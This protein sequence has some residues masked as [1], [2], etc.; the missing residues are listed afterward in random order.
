MNSGMSG[1]GAAPWQG[2]RIVV[3][4]PAA[5][6]AALCAAIRQRGGEPLCFP[7]LVIEP[8][9]DCGELAAIA[10][11]LDQ[12]DIAFFVSP[13]AVGHALPPLLAE[14]RWPPRLAVATVGQ[15]SERAL[16]AFGFE[17]V[18]APAAGFDSEAVLA[19]PEFASPAVC[20]RRVVIFRGDGGR[21]LFGTTLVERG[22]EVEYVTCYRR[23]LPAADP[24][25]LLQAAAAGG[26]AA[27]LLTSSEG[28]RN[29]AALVGEAGM[30]VLRAVP[31]FASHPRIAAHARAVGFASVVETAAGDAG[32]LHALEQHF[33]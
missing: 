21:D 33:G 1:A 10:P 12:F 17:R 3:T 26:L 9:T 14:R 27:I 29:L 32:L 2:R 16:H 25:P 6:A 11:R 8:A 18:I 5:Q 23:A 20:G 4:R 24:A 15:G 28:V 19:L 31:V 7:L 13:N 22:A 30:A